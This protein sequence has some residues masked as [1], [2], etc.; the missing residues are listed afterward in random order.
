MWTPALE[1]AVTL[2]DGILPPRAYAPMT[3]AARGIRRLNC[4][5]IVVAHCQIHES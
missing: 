5:L 2:Q 4:Y 3:L 1:G